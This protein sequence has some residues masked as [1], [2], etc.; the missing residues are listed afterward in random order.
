MFRWRWRATAAIPDDVYEQEASLYGYF[1]A[2]APAQIAFSV[3]PARGV[4]NGTPA[5]LVGLHFCKPPSREVRAALAASGSYEGGV[6]TLDRGAIG[7]IVARV[8][9][10][11]STWHGTEL[12]KNAQA[13]LEFEYGHGSTSTRVRTA[14]RLYSRVRLLLLGIL[15]VQ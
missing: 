1:C 7:G 5:V 13:V 6:I 9:G 15:L 12:P 11:G 4:A 2:G 8:S 10:A 14:V 3:N